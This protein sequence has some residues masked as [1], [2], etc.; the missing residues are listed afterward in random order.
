MENPESAENRRISLLEEKIKTYE[1]TLIE[2]VQEIEKL[3]DENRRISLIGLI[4]PFILDPDRQ[5]LIHSS[6]IETLTKCWL[7]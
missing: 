7:K 6:N 2:K 1:A 3:K 4:S 5:Y